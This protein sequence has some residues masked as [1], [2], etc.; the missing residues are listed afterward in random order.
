ML[1]NP[2]I[3]FS[4]TAL[5]LNMGTRGCPET[6]VADYQPPLRDIP[7]ERRSH[8]FFFSYNAT[9]LH[10]RLSLSLKICDSG[11]FSFLCLKHYVSKSVLFASSG[12]KNMTRISLGSLY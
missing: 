8:S 10:I 7:E 4:W 6:S 11:A 2:K 3:R 12:Y 5:P 9:N 1:R